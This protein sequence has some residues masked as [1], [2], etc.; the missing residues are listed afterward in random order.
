MGDS[1]EA[2]RRRQ[3]LPSDRVVVPNTGIELPLNLDLSRRDILK[4]AGYGSLAAFIAACGGTT[5]TTTTSVTAKGGSMSLGSYLSDAVPKKGLRDV[6]DAFTA[7]NGGTKVKVNTVDHGTYQNQINSYLQGT[8]EDVFTWFSGHR[9]RFFA[10]K[11]LAQPIDDVWND[12]KGNFTEGFAASVKGNDGKVYAIPTSYYPWALFYRKDVFAAGNYKVPTNWD[13]LKTLAD[14]M[15][16]D[17]LIPIAFA[18]KDGWPAM[19]TFDI[20]NLR[21]NGYDFHT[22][23][24]V[25][26]QKWTDPRVANVFKK[27]AEITP[28]YSPAFA[29]LTWQE[30][31]QQLL[32]K[33]AG[34]YLLGL[35]VSEQFVGSGNP[36]DLAQLDFFPFPDL[37]TQY[38]S[39]K[40]LDAPIDV[41]MLAKKSPT[42]GADSGQAKAFLEFLSKGSTQILYWK[43]SPG[44]IPTANDADPSQYPALTKKAAQIVS[45][46][47]RITQ[48]FDRDSRPDFSGPNSMQG[49]L[50][51][52][53]ANPRSDTSS[54][55]GEMQKF[56]DSLPPE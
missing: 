7:A 6:V 12:V 25:G 24:C 44:A 20:I 15:K 2:M 47:K 18:D 46:A 36:D 35:F 34:M 45:N 55:Q 9:M 17:G 5:T 48:F 30:A 16:K 19:G 26:K 52:Y 53:L 56:W 23:L 29:G 11:G 10:D 28:Y 49:F 38:D 54:L 27:W 33:K 14:Q 13:E 50:L 39:E 41:Y 8:P 21:I 43:S 3:Q 42:L 31:A 22:E 40:A 1:R 4:I 37:G 51:K 32:H